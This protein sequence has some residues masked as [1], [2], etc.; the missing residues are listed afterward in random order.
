MSADKGYDDSKLIKRLWD[1]HN[2][3]P[4]IYIRNCWRDGDDDQDG[5]VTKLV[6]GQ[7]NVIHTYDGQVS[8][9][10][11]QTDSSSPRLQLGT[12]MP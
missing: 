11:P 2:I 7:R 8:C 12:T 9:M 3:K 1:Q 4:I 6:N 5:A 10:C